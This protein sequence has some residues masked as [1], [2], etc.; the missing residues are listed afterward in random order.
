LGGL[1]KKA[2]QLEK[3]EQLHE[4]PH[5]ILDAG[6]LLFK[7]GNLSAGLLMQAKITA[8]GIIDS[9]NQMGYDAVAVGLNDLAAG[10]KFLQDKTAES[11]FTWI[12]ANLVSKSD[13][14]PLFSPSLIRKIGSLSV[15]IIG[16]TDY[17]ASP[18]FS[19]KE[20]V[21]L[22]PWQSVLPQL[23]ADLAPQCDLI[24][25]LS[26]CSKKQNEAIAES[27]A[28]LHIIFEA[29]PQAKNSEPELKNNTLLAM[30]G[31][32]GKY[33]GWMLVN[34]QKSQIWG[35]IGD[36][37]ELAL[38]K[39]ELDGINV[40]ISRMERRE[41]GK[42]ISGDVGYQKLVAS[43]EK[44]LSEIIFLKNQLSNLK[45]SGREPS[46]FENHFIALEIGLPDQPEVAGIVKETK[47]KINQAGRTHLNTVTQTASRPE[48]ELKNLPFTGWQTCA[49]CH[50]TQTEFWLKT[51]HAS[52]YQTL[53]EQDQQFNLDCLPCHVTSEYKDVKVGEDEKILL[54]L[55]ATLQQVG[56][57]ICHGP[58]KNHAD[59]QLSTAILRK[60]D[61]AICLRCHTAERDENFNY[62]NDIQKIACPATPN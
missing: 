48:P 59:L 37:K 49:E 51:D 15:G 20:A 4:I 1:S 29:M 36:A 11:K 13:A 31:K 22:L 18:R 19:G 5:L 17:E 46:T 26:N 35:K 57:E 55:P 58:G 25:L 14:K 38:K 6:D 40:R 28:N 50:K 54:S 39:Q 7:Q 34:W 45:E 12:S 43:K 52:A 33:L 2:F 41:Q 61:I 9:Y 8:E 30:T 27:F 21:E 24:I 44:L 62:I 53:V 16:L 56:C 42:D 3:I 23:M 10:L 47:Q 32:Q 60:P